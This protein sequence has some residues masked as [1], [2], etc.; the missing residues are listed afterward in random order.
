MK[1]KTILAAVLSVLAFA[2]PSVSAQSIPLGLSWTNRADAVGFT[3]TVIYASQN[4]NHFS[5]LVA[6][7]ANPVI[8]PSVRKFNAGTATNATA[9]I[10]AGTRWYF[11]GVNQREGL[12]SAA[13]NLLPYTAPTTPG[14][15][16][17]QMIVNFPAGT[18]V[19]STD[20]NITITFPSPP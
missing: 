3:N 1:L 8:D 7:V 14:A 18:V 6:G 13:S 4:S 2:L 17:M 20:T 19:T 11:V 15:P 9:T 12:Q 10:I 5:V 16:A